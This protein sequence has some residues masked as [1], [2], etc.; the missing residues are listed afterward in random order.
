MFPPEFSPLKTIQFGN[1]SQDTI[2]QLM[3]ALEEDYKYGNKMN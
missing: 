3:E 1:P 2:E